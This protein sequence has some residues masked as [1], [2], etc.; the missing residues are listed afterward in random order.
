M[1]YSQ[2][3]SDRTVNKMYLAGW[4]G[5]VLRTNWTASIQFSFI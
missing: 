5:T 4:T 2:K 3:I 1:L